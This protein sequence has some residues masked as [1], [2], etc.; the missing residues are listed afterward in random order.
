MKRLGLDWPVGSFHVYLDKTSTDYLDPMMLLRDAVA[1]HGIRSD[2]VLI[3]KTI[4]AAAAPI[5]QG[6]T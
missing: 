4:A 5:A 6:N 3:V 1:K 2:S